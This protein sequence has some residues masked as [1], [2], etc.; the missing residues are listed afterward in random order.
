MKILDNTLE[1]IEEKIGIIYSVSPG[2]EAM[3][4]KI[5]NLSQ[6]RKV[7]DKSRPRYKLIEKTLSDL[8]EHFY[9]LELPVESNKDEILHLH[10]VS[11]LERFLIRNSIHPLRKEE[12]V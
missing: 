1:V 3:L 4:H 10:N 7:W 11:F 5:G 2:T 8:E 9:L 6:V 12:E